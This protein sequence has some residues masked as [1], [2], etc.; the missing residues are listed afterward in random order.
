MTGT[1]TRTPVSVSYRPF[2]LWPSD[3]RPTAP[4][5]KTVYFSE[6]R[7]KNFSDVCHEKEVFPDAILPDESGFTYKV[8]EGFG[9]PQLVTG[10]ASICLKPSEKWGTNGDVYEL[11][12]NGKYVLYCNVDLVDQSPTRTDVRIY[13]YA[14]RWPDTDPKSSATSFYAPSGSYVIGYRID[15]PLGA[16]P[17][18]KKLTSNPRPRN[19][20]GFDVDEILDMVKGFV[21]AQSLSRRD[22]E[23]ASSCKRLCTYLC[24]LLMEFIFQNPSFNFRTVKYTK[25]QPELY[26]VTAPTFLLNEPEAIINGIDDILLNNG[27]AAYFRNVLIQHAYLEAINNVPRM[28]DNNISNLL[29]IVGFIK[30]VVIDH[31][32]ELPKS[33]SDGWLAYRYQYG[34][35]KM[36]A[37]EAISYV[38]RR[39]SL[40]GV[41][42]IK[43]YGE[44]TYTYKNTPIT[45]RCCFSVKNKLLSTV[46]RIWSQLSEYG[47]TPSF[48]VVWDMIPFSFIADWFLPIGDVM[49][50]WDAERR[51][52]M[53]YEIEDVNFSLSYEKQAPT[54]RSYTFYTRWWSGTPIPLQGYY[55]LEDEPVSDKTFGYRILDAASLIMG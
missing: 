45:C 53:F 12:N 51:V 30:S 17:K 44:Y 43:C 23:A 48:Y 36:D 5:R 27:N 14:D 16:E 19:D 29:E 46:D 40:K 39:I 50:A 55:F 3:R 49:A 9:I 18:W 33:I 31:K 22:G 15:Y 24:H 13:L 34:T 25:A 42:K 37:E 35:T 41:R 7:R 54:G 11:H 1:D 38:K 21:S 10:Q 4:R 26:D 6:K 32:V 8:G 52:E 28:S 20:F 47:L 2:L